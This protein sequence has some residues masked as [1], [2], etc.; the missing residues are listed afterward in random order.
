[1]SRQ[2]WFIL[3]L[4][5][6]LFAEGLSWITAS[7]P[8]RP[9]LVQQESYKEA[10]HQADQKH[11]A[12]FFA[13]TIIVASR[14]VDLIKRDD[15]DKAIVAA[16]TIVLAF[17]TIGLWVATLQ[18]WR[19][20]DKLWKA[21]ERQLE[22]IETNASQQS[23]DT[24]SALGISEKQMAISGF[25][26]DIQRKQHAV[27]RLQFFATHRPRLRVR[28]VS[29]YDP[30]ETT[31]LPT[32]F[33]SHGSEIKGGLVVVNIGGSNATI[34]ETRHRIFFS[35]TGLPASAPY[36]EDFRPYML[37][38]DLIM[39]SGES[40]TTPITDTIVMEPDP[41]GVTR[42]RTFEREGWQIFVMGQIRYKDDGGAERFM[43][44][45]RVRGSNGRFRPVDDIDYEYED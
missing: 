45:C 31:R 20:T 36:D 39:A 41:E 13:G 2:D 40:C 1:M 19:S 37:L 8:G 28:H 30:G 18:L 16:F 34:I 24:K 35:K 9:C 22:L 44:F 11:C 21:G 42:L 6:F 15:N 27:A 3:C 12:T 23:R 26:T 29:I 25:Q 43:G 38:P 4:C 14:A 33:F 5:Y 32:F 7:W 17:S 10:A